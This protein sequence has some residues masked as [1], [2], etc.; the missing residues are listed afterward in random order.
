LKRVASH[1][2]WAARYL[3]RA[4]WRARLVDVNYHLLVE[5][6]SQPEEGWATL[7]L[8]TGDRDEFA[9]RY[10]KSDE[11]SVLNFST[12]DES[13]PS[14]IC[15]CIGAA[16]ENCHA[17][18][19]RISSELWI[20]LNTLFL[21]SRGWTLETLQGRGVYSFFAALQERFYRLS[22]VIENTLPH[23]LGYDFWNVGRRLEATENVSRLLDAKYHFLLPRVE[24]VGSALDLSQ[25][26]ALL[27]SASALEAYRGTYGNSI[28][29]AQVV[30]FLLF[31]ANFPRAARFSIDRLEGAL[32]RISAVADRPGTSR[33]TTAAAL[34]ARLHEDIATTVIASGLHGYLLG[35]QEDCARIGEEVF[36]NYLKFE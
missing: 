35:I 23:D 8:V 33:M 34:Q 20:E 25:W 30:E 12:F 11:A 9:G 15:K 10:A 27:R 5:S 2:F 24:D 7:L 36:A 32:L 6:Q 3:E 17:L 28:T 31:E 16:R 19:N 29:V 22:G 1:L 21:D 14:S 26:A 13:N 18:R 4:E